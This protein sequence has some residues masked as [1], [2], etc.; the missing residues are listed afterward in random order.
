VIGTCVGWRLTASALLLIPCLAQWAV[1]DAKG[2]PPLAPVPQSCPANPLFH[3]NMTA[4]AAAPA[5]WLMVQH[6]S[7]NSTNYALSIYDDRYGWVIKYVWFMKLGFRGRVTV[8]GK[9]LSGGPPLWLGDD[10]HERITRVLILDAGQFV[11]T[12]SPEALAQNGIHSG[13]YLQRAG[14][15]RLD[16][17]CPGGHWHGVFSF[18]K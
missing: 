18:G 15:Y 12:S 8:Q 1:V 3:T 7:I 11:Q 14:C 16:A 13:L 17:T 10:L 9:N 4:Y 6:P 2:P 5:R